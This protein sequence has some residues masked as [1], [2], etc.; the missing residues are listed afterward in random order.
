MNFT[1]TGFQLGQS[2][3]VASN[4]AVLATPEDL[5]LAFLHPS[6]YIA[7]AEGIECLG[8]GDEWSLAYS[9]GYFFLDYIARELLVNASH[10]YRST[11]PMD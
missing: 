2:V 1:G 6:F 3:F 4:L 11:C 8:L 9:L 10:C 5:D 7:S